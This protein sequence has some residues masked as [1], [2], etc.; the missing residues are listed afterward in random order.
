VAHVPCGQT[1]DAER[2]GEGHDRTIDKAEAK[3]R[4]A[5][6]DLHRPCELTGRRRR[7]GERTSREI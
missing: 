1:T 3:I 7:V 4:E 6:I 5:S 2:L